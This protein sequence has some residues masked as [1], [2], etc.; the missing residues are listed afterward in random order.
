MRASDKKTF[1]NIPTSVLK[2]GN[3]KSMEISGDYS[4]SFATPSNLAF[5]Y[6]YNRSNR[7]KEAKTSEKNFDIE[8]TYDKDG[9]F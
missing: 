5:E 3:V 6:E 7:L 9:I 2:N 4:L 8:T 1:L